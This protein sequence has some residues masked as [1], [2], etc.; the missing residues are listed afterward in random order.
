MNIR[1]L[2]YIRMVAKLGHFGRAAEACNVSQPALST[3]IK[4]LELELGV[5]LFERDNRTFRITKIGEKIIQLADEALD[6]IDTI[7]ATAEAAHDPFSGVFTLGSIPTISPYLVPQFVR[8]THTALPALQLEFQE[9]ITERLNENLLEGQ[10]D[11]AILA[12][13]PE[14]PKLD[15]IPLYD[16]PFWALFPT[17]HTLKLTERLRTEDLPVD[18]LLLLSEGHCFRDQAL[19]ICR[20]GPSIEKRAIRA[21]SLE[22]LIN[23]VAA[24]QGITLVPAMALSG[25][26]TTDSRVQASKLAD[27]TASRRI[28][29]TYR[30]SFPRRQLL[31]QMAD[32]ICSNLPSGV[33]PIPATG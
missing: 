21:T 22:T 25:G 9:D 29:L 12:T 6:V 4:K 24:G 26:W 28:Y 20:L 18:E 11:A 5:N 13:L 7:K 3:Q 15:V 33:E 10:L 30:K 17:H 31:E 2:E 27:T 8:Q 1:D 32:V 14:S 19:D 23:M 16:E